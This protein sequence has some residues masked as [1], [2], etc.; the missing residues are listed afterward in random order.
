MNPKQR[1][2]KIRE[3]AKTYNGIVSS[4]KNDPPLTRANLNELIVRADE[5][6]LR[7]IAHAAMDALMV[8]DAKR[9]AASANAISQ[10]CQDAMAAMQVKMVKMQQAL[11][12]GK[13]ARIRNMSKKAQAYRPEKRGS[14][15][16]PFH[17]M[18]GRKNRNRHYA[19]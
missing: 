3:R 17:P 16:S 1:A 9:D 7:M 15:S 2:R 5:L 12:G 6:G 8:A 14:S 13:V 19:R 18:S 11:E 4:L 10:Q